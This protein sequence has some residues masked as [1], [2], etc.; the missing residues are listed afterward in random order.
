MAEMDSG[1]QLNEQG[2]GRYSSNV[3]LRSG[4]TWQV[5][6]TAVQGGKLTLTKRL[7]ITAT[8]GM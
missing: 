7:N 3:D 5:T 1:V 2:N 8:G 6:I 4:G